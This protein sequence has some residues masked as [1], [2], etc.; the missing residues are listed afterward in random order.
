MGVV[1][2]S[3]SLFAGGLKAVLAG[4]ATLVAGA[5][6]SYWLLRA[7]DRSHTG[8]LHTR[9]LVHQFST[10]SP[11]APLVAGLAAVAAAVVLLSRRT[12]LL[13]GVYLALAL[14]PGMALVGAALASGDGALALRALGRWSLDAGAVIVLGG[15]VLAGA[16]ATVLR[17]DPIVEPAPG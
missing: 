14:V 3:R 6:G 8:D 2:R 7:L 12:L 17:R 1:V 5:A 15:L 11:T 13:S 10:I 9:G 16:Q 4:Y